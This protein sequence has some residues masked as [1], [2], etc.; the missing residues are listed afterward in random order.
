MSVDSPLPDIDLRLRLRLYGALGYDLAFEFQPEIP[1]TR[2]RK[3]DDRTMVFLHSR[4][5]NRHRSGR[6]HEEVHNRLLSAV[7]H[8]IPADTRGAVRAL[9]QR[10]SD[11]ELA[12][13]HRA[14]TRS[15]SA[16]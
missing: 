10:H 15:L 9:Y 8:F 14:D 11:I 13:P 12:A 2:S 5:G 4:G 1:L 16:Y 7:S 3:D 6:G